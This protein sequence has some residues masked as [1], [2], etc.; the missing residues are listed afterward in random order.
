M[1]DGEIPAAAAEEAAA[2][3]AAEAAEVTEAEQT[4]DQADQADQAAEAAEAV[5]EEEVMDSEPEPLP[6]EPPVRARRCEDRNPSCRTWAKA[7][8]CERNVDYMRESCPA[9]CGSC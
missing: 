7:G 9:S 6:Q 5:A 1:P 2:E 8:E 3:A 4:A